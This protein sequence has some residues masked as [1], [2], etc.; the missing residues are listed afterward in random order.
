MAATATQQDIEQYAYLHG[1]R[2]W[3]NLIA[4]G[5]AIKE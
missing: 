5:E 4:I 3:R 1:I 2:F